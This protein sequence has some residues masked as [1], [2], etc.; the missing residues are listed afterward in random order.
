MSDKSD[1]HAPSTSDFMTDLNT[2]PTAANVTA[3]IIQSNTDNTPAVT[4]P[5][6]IPVPYR[7]QPVSKKHPSYELTSEET[8]DFVARKSRIYNTGSRK[9]NI[10]F[11]CNYEYVVCLLVK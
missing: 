11:L 3:Y 4:F 8:I 9:Q 7:E 5:N 10:C 2:V 6:L 1:N